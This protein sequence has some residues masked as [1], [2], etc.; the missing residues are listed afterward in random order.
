M[1]VATVA[2]TLAAFCFTASALAGVTTLADPPLTRITELPLTPE[3]RA[4]LHERL[5]LRD[6]TLQRIELTDA[7]RGG[8]IVVEFVDGGAALELDVRPLRSSGFRVI[9]HRGAERVAT[10][11]HPSLTLRGDAIVERDPQRW[12]AAVTIENDRLRAFLHAEDG[13]LRA[14]QPLTD[15]DPSADPQLYVA[16]RGTDV[17]PIEGSCGTIA[18]PKQG[19]SGAASEWKTAAASTTLKK[20]DLAIEGDVAYFVAKGNSIPAAQAD[21]ETI[22]N[23]IT[24]IYEAEVGITYGISTLLLE[25]DGSE[26]YGGTNSE[27]LL[28][29]FRAYWNSNFGSIQ[30]DTVHLI[31]GK[32]L[33]SNII[34]LAYVGVICNKNFGYGLSESTFSANML[35]RVAVTAHEIGHNWNANHCN[36][37]VDC[38]IM[39]SSIGG[40]SGQLQS[41]GNFETNEIED[42]RDQIGCLTNVLPPA[43]APFLETFEASSL[44]KSL[45]KSGGGATLSTKAIGETSGTRAVNLDGGSKPDSLVTNAIDYSGMGGSAELSFFSQNR[46]AEVGENLIVEYVDANG[47][48]QLLTQVASTGTKD[49]SFQN[50]VVVLPGAA[51][52]PD[53]KLR[54]RTTGDQGNDDWYFDDVEVRAVSS[55]PNYCLS[56]SPPNPI[57]AA[58]PEDVGVGT[59]WNYAL[60][61]WNCDEASGSTMIP[62]SKLDGADGPDPWFQFNVFGSSISGGEF[63]PCNLSLS[64]EPATTGITHSAIE[65]TAVS[66]PLARGYLPICYIKTPATYFVAG[67]GL[68]GSISVADDTDDAWFVGTE[69]ETLEF[70]ASVPN[71]DLKATI[72]ITDLAETTLAVVKLKAKAAPQNFSFPVPE[73][74][75]YRLRVSGRSGTTGAYSIAT[76]PKFSGKAVTKTYKLKPS[77]SGG[78][79]S[80]DASLLPGSFLDITVV[81]VVS[82]TGPFTM[83]YSNSNFSALTAGLFEKALPTGGKLFRQ[84]PMLGPGPTAVTI[85]GFA[86]QEAIYLTLAPRPPALGTTQHTID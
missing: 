60:S 61:V 67:D 15:I 71:S 79:V 75:L 27:T 14:V 83:T 11:S 63:I 46:G 7:S 58:N 22:F 20:A 5:A 65:T 70:T 21:L 35:Q 85:S 51:L 84:V 18:L 68:S 55:P 30:R 39:C 38:A 36:G 64:G 80:A 17:E 12:R 45:W 66:L 25:T 52:I 59:P 6:A 19:S 3:L 74:G 26:Q 29:N 56:F 44:D 76:S 82:G 77:T 9:E 48:W 42:F 8:T 32:N 28:E 41:F 50:T 16:Y 43:T 10:A 4:S 78:S 40:C 81:P 57:V 1:R 86:D 34:G 24:S 49:P 33:A 73:A 62:I 54:F 23:S 69:D 47:D 72:T 37:Q 31:T 53:G 13:S 2:L